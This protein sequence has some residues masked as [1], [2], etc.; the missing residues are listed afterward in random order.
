MVNK[1]PGPR[2]RFW[3]K[4]MNPSAQGDIIHQALTPDRKTTTGCIRRPPRR[5]LGSQSVAVLLSATPA[6]EAHARRLT[7]VSIQT[8]S[9]EHSGVR[10]T[11][12]RKRDGRPSLATRRILAASLC[13]LCRSS[14]RK[15]ACAFMAPSARR[16]SCCWHPNLCRSPAAHTALCSLE[17]R[18]MPLNSSPDPPFVFSVFKHYSRNIPFMSFWCTAD[19]SETSLLCAFLPTPYAPWSS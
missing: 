19:T 18:F 15:V 7:V 17:S 6:S 13:S 1:E 5:H 14:I 11:N 3:Y 2:I 12:E 9:V 8:A 10:M 4:V 16:N